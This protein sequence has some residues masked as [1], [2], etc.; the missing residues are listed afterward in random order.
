MIYQ[1][2]TKQE[3]EKELLDLKDRFEEYKILNMKLDMSRGKPSGEQ[4]DLSEGLLTTVTQNEQ[5]V[6]ENGL[7]ARNYGGFDGIPEIKRLF[8]EVLGVPADMLMIGGVSSLN[9]MY[10]TFARNMIFGAGEGMQPWGKGP[11]RFLCPSPGYDRHFGVSECFGAELITVP[12]TDEGP[13]MDVVESLVKTDPSI[14]GIWCVPKYS[15]PTGVTYSEETVRRLVSMPTAA[16]DFRIFWD[17]AYGIHDLYDEGDTLAEI[18]S[19]A[20]QYGNEDRVYEFASF[21]KVT[22]CGGSV[23]ALAASPRNLAHAKKYLAKQF[24]CHDKINQL[25]HARFFG[26]LEGLK[27]HMKKHA[28]LLRPKFEAVIGAFERKLAVCGVGSWSRPRGGYFISLDLPEGTAK[29]THALC[30]ELGVVLTPAGATYPYGK[31]P[32]DSNLR[33]A[34][35]YPTPED[36]RSATEVLCLCAKIA[37]CEKEI[38]LRTSD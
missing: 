11:I 33:I 24:I 22:Y 19:L 9:L 31:D 36:L 3:L 35:S 30:T 4:L 27:A 13:D 8:S 6:T 16:P 17:N 5:C 37:A 28:A 14:K 18:F 15:N 32:H 21:A 2:A 20:K 29:R 1:N 38:S 26:D 10:D 12:M 23:S 7:D 25:R 34:P